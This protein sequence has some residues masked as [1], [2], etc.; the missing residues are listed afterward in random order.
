MLDKLK[1]LEFCFVLGLLY[2]ANA[3]VK[4]GTAVKINEKPPYL[5]LIK[6][7]FVEIHTN[8]D[9]V[10]RCGGI[11][12]NEFW[13]ITAAHC[14]EP[15]LFKPGIKRMD[16]SP[17]IDI[18]A[19]DITFNPGKVTTRQ[20]KTSRH[21][22]IHTDYDEVDNNGGLV[23]DIALAKVIVKFEFNQRVQPALLSNYQDNLN[24]NFNEPK[25]YCEIYGWGSNTQ[26]QADNGEGNFRLLKGEVVY[27][28][29]GS[30]K[31]KNIIKFLPADS[32]QGPTGG[33]SGG[34]LV[35]KTKGEPKPLVYAIISHG[36]KK[37]EDI[38]K[39]D[40]VENA[41][42]IHP[43]KDWIAQQV[44]LK[45]PTQPIQFNPQKHLKIPDFVVLL[46]FKYASSSPVLKCH[47]AA[48]NKN[49]VITAAVCFDNYDGK[50]LQSI[51]AVVGLKEVTSLIPSDLLQGENKVTTTHWFKHRVEG[52]QIYD[53]GL[54]HFTETINL[55]NE[56]FGKLPDE[57]ITINPGYKL[58][59][60]QL[61]GDDYKIE[62]FYP[63]RHNFAE[64]KHCP[65]E[66]IEISSRFIK[67]RTKNDITPHDGILHGNRQ[68][69]VGVKASGEVH[70]IYTKPSKN[71]IKIEKKNLEWARKCIALNNI[72]EINHECK[73]KE[74][75]E[76]F[77]SSDTGE[78]YS[79]SDTGESCSSSDTD[80]SY[81]SS[82]TDESYSS[83]DTG[84]SCSSSDTYEPP[85][86]KGRLSIGKKRSDGIVSQIINYFI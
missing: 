68:Q 53:V 44:N 19:G 22:V 79:S 59:Y 66:A 40:A 58:T 42:K 69:I 71:F 38:G 63:T 64:L 35:C 28:T 55:P 5:V 10:Y 74:T 78:S 85:N 21:W 47:G 7:K 12:L 76:L 33:D 52:E 2:F 62:K 3:Q 23:N 46:Y 41:M 20:E 67:V 36:P 13:V 61:K 32:K 60:W 11:I 49:W 43:Y 51:T 24:P 73:E 70:S 8:E 18:I 16:I 29:S 82:D 65:V 45:T 37:F 80:E 86:K 6:L 56:K 57:E 14:F 75:D 81:S 50:E 1:L 26:V 72:D 25:I 15:S 27:K 84:E 39:P 4:D 31:Y 77:S 30:G 34:P 48:I 17:V 54:L 9:E 83:S